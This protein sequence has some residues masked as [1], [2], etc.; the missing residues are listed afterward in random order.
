MSFH[1]HTLLDLI[2]MDFP[3]K[4]GA[5]GEVA[6]CAS[7]GACQMTRAHMASFHH[8]RYKQRLMVVLRFLLERDMLRIH[9]VMFQ[10]VLISVCSPLSFSGSGEV[11][12]HQG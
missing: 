3:F 8:V 5:V 2:G 10:V 4:M 7:Q 12:L 11:H 6:R 1:R 9:N